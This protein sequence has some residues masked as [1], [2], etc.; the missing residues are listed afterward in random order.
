MSLD[1]FD[2]RLTGNIPEDIG[3][4]RKLDFLGLGF[5]RISGEIPGSIGNLTSVQS[6][7][8]GG[9]ELVGELPPEISRLTQL[10]Y[11]DLFRNR[12]EGPIPASLA[13]LSALEGLDLSFNRF[14]GSIPPGARFDAQP[15]VA[16]ARF[17]THWRARCTKTSSAFFESD[18]TFV[19]LEWNALTAAEPLATRL[20]EHG[21]S[22][23]QTGP[24]TPF[25]VFGV[26]SQ[27]VLLVWETS[28]FTDLNGGYAVEHLR[29]KQRAVRFRW[30]SS[31]EKP[32]RPPSSPIFRAARIT[33]AFGTVTEP[34]VN[35]QNRLVS[36]AS[37]AI[38]GPTA[39]TTDRGGVT[40]I[41][42]E[43][44]AA[45]GE[46]KFAEVWRLQG[47]AGVLNATV[48]VFEFR[49]NDGPEEHIVKLRW[50]DGEA[51]KKA[52]KLPFMVQTINGASLLL[53]GSL[54]QPDALDSSFIFVI[55]PQGEGE[56]VL[57]SQG[58]QPEVAT[59][60]F[61]EK[62]VVWSAPD[63]DSQGVL[64]SDIRRVRAR[65]R[66]ADSDE[67]DYNWRPGPIPRSPGTTRTAGS[68]P[69][70]PARRHPAHLWLGGSSNLGEN[71]S[72]RSS[73]STKPTTQQN[74]RVQRSPSATEVR[75]S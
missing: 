8:L 17:R 21:F 3:N 69:P 50:E 70:G 27:S 54:L 44:Y 11:L 4:L 59:S 47:S 5:N 75:S 66:P 60:P 19:Q 32:P 25:Q 67:R 9:N 35:N 29:G 53:E 7:Y 56:I 74:T 12:L 55:E 36:A 64:Q 40:F 37:T 71:H 18:E 33:F 13:G 61:G 24:P 1:V 38:S 39:S 22:Y 63:D 31:R 15:E 14:T 73:A 46:S 72:Q 62:V 42:S 48:T 45:I 30:H 58:D 16:P 51:G 68:L 49:Q 20:E 43:I 65:D 57:A 52:F 34:H 41:T 6:I 28:D 23:T 26:D 10:Q 2:N